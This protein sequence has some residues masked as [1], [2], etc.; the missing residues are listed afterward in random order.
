MRDKTFYFKSGPRAVLLFHA[1][2]STPNDVLS[3]GR[4]LERKGYTVYAP[5]FTGHNTPHPEDVLASS[6]EEWTEDAHA[7]LQFLRSEGYTSIA[8]FGL[9][10]GGVMAM[11]LMLE[12][13]LVGGGVFA[14]PVMP[15]A[16]IRVAPVYWSYLDDIYTQAGYKKQDIRAM[17]TALE[18]KLT[19]IV[20]DL[21]NKAQ[22]M[23]PAYATIRLPVFIAQGG[24][25]TIVSPD[26][27]FDFADALSH[28]RVELKWYATGTHA[29]T[30]GD[31]RTE[32]QKDVLLF[33]DRLD[34]DGGF[35]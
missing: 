26:S 14:S 28:A 7:A 2:S 20:Q 9:S 25:D 34:W 33:L 10:L 12:G 5:T 11:H 29:L 30:V 23:E 24:D 27:A 6:V 21:Q 22:K 8:A 18:P 13:G 1:F 15:T 31:Y 35:R 19:Q 17:H 16:Q 4:A 3:L 32:L